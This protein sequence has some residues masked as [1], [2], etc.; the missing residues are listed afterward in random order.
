MI[1]RHVVITSVVLLAL[2]VSL[3]IYVWQV[4]RREATT[5]ITTAPEQRL[6]PPAAGPMEKVTVWIAYDDSGTLRA[7][8]A[9]IPLASGRQQRAR[10]LLRTLVDFYVAKGSPHPLQAGSDIH[11][12][13]LVEPGLAV[14]DVNAAFVEGQIS[15]VL[16]E[17]L[18]VASIIH[19]LSV[20]IPALIRVK[21]L[22]DGKERD[23]LAGHAD[24]SGFYEV[25]Q[26][27]ELAKQL[28]SH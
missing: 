27:D 9:S 25:S 6:P 8:A 28:S 22:V 7:Q 3:S 21:I 24:L 12:V 23:T 17:D 15:G 13:Y 20:N 2:A 1:P 18:T 4:R 14:I 5:P 11:S 26:V 19:T 10:E 16:A